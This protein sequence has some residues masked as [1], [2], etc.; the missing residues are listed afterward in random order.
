MAV[1][2]EEAEA[3]VTFQLIVL[4]DEITR[5]SRVTEA[6]VPQG[7]LKNSSMIRTAMLP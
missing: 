1:L 4:L 6:R 5:V 2:Y 7:V 3:H